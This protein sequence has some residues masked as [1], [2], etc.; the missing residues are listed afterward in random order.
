MAEVND[1]PYSGLNA[2]S[3]F[4]GCG[5]SSLGYRMA[6]YRM[7]AACE[8]IPA[9]QET[10]RANF[11]S[12]P[13]IAKDIREVTA[14]YLMQ[15]AGLERGELDLLDGS[16]PCSSFSMIGKREAGWGKAKH[17]SDGVKQRTDDLFVEFLRLVDGMRPRVVVAENVPG[18]VRGKA[19]GVFKQIMAHFAK[20]GYR[21]GAQVLEAQWLGVPQ[22]RSRLIIVAVRDDLE[23]DPEFPRPL[24]YRYT[25]RDAFGGVDEIGMDGIRDAETGYPIELRGNAHQVSHSI[26]VGTYPKGKY[27]SLM[28][29]HPDR[30]APTITAGAATGYGSCHGLV[31]RRF[32]LAELRRIGSF[33]DDFALTGAY[34]QRAERIGRAV[35]P[36]MMRAVAATVRD[37]IL[38]PVGA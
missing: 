30:P 26:P 1:I 18:L 11:P 19:M 20:L 24:D 7:L 5:G 4:S 12:T 32:S 17:Y 36:L 22:T 37:R 33:P 15:V 8:F 25:I 38:S 10:Y 13:L 6:G 27:F 9:A 21:A 35:P 2:V 23:R 29:S 3:T 31:P 28:K 34:A 16:P 14:D